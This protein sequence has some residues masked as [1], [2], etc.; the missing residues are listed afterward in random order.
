M[1]AFIEKLKNEHHNE[2]ILKVVIAVFDNGRLT[3]AEYDKEDLKIA[4]L[5]IHLEFGGRKLVGF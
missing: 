1:E 4:I 5:G 3:C 2:F